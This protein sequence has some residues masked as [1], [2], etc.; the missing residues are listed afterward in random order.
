VKARI[1][2]CWSLSALVLVPV[3]ARADS[4]IAQ[5]LGPQTI[6]V[7]GFEN[8][9]LAYRTS[10]GSRSSRPYEKVKQLIVDNESALSAAEAANAA[11]RPAAAV[12]DYVK[13][14][15]GTTTPWVKAYAARRLTDALGEGADR[16]DARLAVYLA[17]L[18][19]AVAA[20]RRPALPDRGSRL[21]DV[22]VADTETALKTPGQ[23]E[24]ATVALLNFLADLHRHRGDEAAVTAVY[25]RLA[26]VSPEAANDPALKAR[27]VGQKVAQ[28]RA[29][30][31]RREYAAARKL[32][33]DNR[34]LI[35][36]P[37]LQ[38]DAL[39]VLAAVAEGIADPTDKPA[40][41]D[42]ALA[43]V[44]VV[45]LSNPLDG[46]PNVLDSLRATATL[47]E[48]AGDKAEA[49]RV[50]TQITQEFAA[51]ADAVSRAKAELARLGA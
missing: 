44:R 16:F 47:L 38:S 5:G 45:A 20:P 13:A 36:D 23:P 1:L 22:A 46:R 48:K 3:A 9:T 21:L 31:G 50:L 8:N 41:Q 27:H 17:Q 51:D 4:L 43:Y 25:D 30:L 19:T 34:T 2:C 37:R 35:T 12:D 7:T 10:A 6:T 11:G 33:Q 15:R 42:A 14:I 40:L 24:A 32:I 28:A 49:A 29:A 26:K 18:Q 39:F